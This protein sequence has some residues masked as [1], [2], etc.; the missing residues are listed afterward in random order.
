MWIEVV[1]Y[2]VVIYIIFV[3]TDYNTLTFSQCIQRLFPIM[4]INDNFVSCFLLFYLCIPF[5]N[6]LVQYISKRQHQLLILLC[7]FIYTNHGTVPGFTVVMNY[8]SWFCVIYII[9]SYLRLHSI[10]V[11]NDVRFWG[12]A[13]ALCIM[14]SVATIVGQLWLGEFF[15]RTTN[16]Y[17]FVSDSNALMAV[18]TAVCTFMLFKNI[19]IPYT[20]WINLVGASTFGVLLLHANSNAMRKWLWR[21]TFD[22]AGHYADEWYWFR[23][24]L[25]VMLVFTVCIIVDRVRIVLLERPLFNFLN[26]IYLENRC[27]IRIRVNRNNL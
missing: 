6:I 8:V 14:L 17:R 19:H 16:P 10:N 9:A 22:C 27:K 25:V 23:P 3:W 2:N 24:F 21:D 4:N 5:L 26:K 13:S 15:Q 18:L 12:I 7:L 1:T 11:G 20:R